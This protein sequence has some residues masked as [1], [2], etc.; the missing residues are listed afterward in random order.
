MRINVW[1][2]SIQRPLTAQVEEKV[3]PLPLCNFGSGIINSCMPLVFVHS[4]DHSGA[5]CMEYPP[6]DS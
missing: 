1:G 4:Q 6:E 2:G 5:Q 3:T